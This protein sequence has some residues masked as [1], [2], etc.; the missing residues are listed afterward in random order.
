MTDYEYDEKLPYV[1]VGVVTGLLA[2][3]FRSGVDAEIYAFGHAYL[4]VIDTT[5]KPS[6]PDDAKFITWYE[7]GNL[8]P[9]YA[10][11]TPDGTWLHDEGIDLDRVDDLPGVTPDTVFTV[12][13]E[14]KN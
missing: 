2:A 3:R 13:D 9:H 10:R 14:R 6:V 4:K 12:L 7:T 8:Y 5:P 1:V 11:R